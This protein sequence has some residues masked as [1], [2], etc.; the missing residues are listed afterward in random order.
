MR[1]CRLAVA[2]WTLMALLVTSVPA[3]AAEAKGVA[4]GAG[5]SISHADLPVSASLRAS[6]TDH[7]VADA[8][9]SR[10][11]IFESPASPAPFKVLTN[12]THEGVQLVLAVLKE[13]GNWFHVRLPVRPNGSTGW[14]KASDVRIRKVPNRIVVDKSDHKLM[15]FKGDQLLMEMPAG[16]GT[17]AT[18]TPEGEYYVDI[19]I[20]FANT[21]GAYGAH[22][23]SIAGFSEVHLNFGG[24]IGQL[25]IHGTNNRASVG[26]NSSNGC[27]RLYNESIQRLKDLAP[28]GTPVSIQA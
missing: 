28:S 22:M 3:V 10:L 8:A 1:F 9:R 12:P 11:S 7:L 5:R 27:V 25:A 6:P 23:L 21:S 2:S 16:I 15:A 4:A 14:V 18:P 26:V 19:S 20:P 17:A 24:G 13:E